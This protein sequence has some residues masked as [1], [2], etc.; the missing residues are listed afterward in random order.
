MNILFLP[1]TLCTGA[2][3]E[4]QIKHLSQYCEQV[5]V[6]SFTTE[7]TLAAM[8]ETVIA[9][10]E[11]KPCALVGFS[12]GGIVAL[13]V[14]KTR[15]ELI[16][17]LALVNSNCHA[18]LP[19]R[20]KARKAQ[21][22]QAQSGQLVELLTSTFLPNY[23][24]K[25]NADHEALILD[26]A[27][28]LGAD[29]FQAQVTAIEDRPDLLKH[30]KQLSA[31]IVIIAGAQDKICPSEHQQMMHNEVAGSELILLEQ[32]AHFSPLEQAEQVSK[33]LAKWYQK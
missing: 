22:A 7:N 5:S 2:M 28:S 3:F 17:K 14:A 32:C 20:K 29:V 12:M 10:T 8:A 27:T 16:A 31:D 19:E 25:A 4:Q 21:I 33:A 24:F 6:V 1:G 23:L 18:D 11:G 13:E 30:L 15:P 9:A 26:M